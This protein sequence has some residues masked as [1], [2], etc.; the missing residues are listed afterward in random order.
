MQFALSEKKKGRGGQ[1][2]PVQ[3]QHLLLAKGVIVG[4]E[5]L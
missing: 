4:E 2:S 5:M 1:E 3:A